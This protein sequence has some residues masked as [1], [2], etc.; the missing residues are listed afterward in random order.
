MPSRFAGGVFCVL[1]SYCDG[2]ALPQK[3]ENEMAFVEFESPSDDPNVGVY[4]VFVD[5]EQVTKVSPASD[6]AYSYVFTSDGATQQ[7]SGGVFGVIAQLES[8]AG[9]LV[10]SAGEFMPSFLVD[11]GDEL[12][13][14]VP[15]RW[16]SIVVGLVR[17]RRLTGVVRVAPNSLGPISVRFALPG[18]IAQFVHED[19]IVG[20]W[21]AAQVEDAILVRPLP[22]I[23][24]VR[25]EN[26]SGVALAGVQM[27]S[28][29]ASQLVQQTINVDITW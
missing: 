29:S 26:Q 8:G 12:A 18:G 21:T 27:L 4:P 25:A 3:R 7:V 9:G 5:A 19:Q 23:A 20:T 10:V 13:V 1:L 24:L 2:A 14:E 15:W 11:T 22:P 6:P 17:V 28:V 16:T